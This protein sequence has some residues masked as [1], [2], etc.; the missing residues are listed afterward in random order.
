[1]ADRTGMI[2][3]LQAAARAAGMRQA[4]IANN[5]ANINTPGFRRSTVEF[6][7]LLGEA[8][9]G[10]QSPASVEPKIVQPGDLPVN[11][12]G[13]DVDLDVEV[14]EMLKN[15]SVYKTYMR[16]MSRVYRQVDQAVVTE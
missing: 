5:I 1:M 16:L 9:S 11:A 2:E 13:N 3:Q 14:G 12:N 4:V 15:A 6:E 8:I 7:K 10:G